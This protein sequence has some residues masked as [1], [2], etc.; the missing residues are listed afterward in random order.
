MSSVRYSETQS[1]NSEVSINTAFISPTI[2][3][4]SVGYGKVLSVRHVAGSGGD[5]AKIVC[6]PNGVDLSP[7]TPDV[8]YDGGEGRQLVVM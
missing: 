6:I 5:P 2:L 7:Y 4:H 3:S 8:A 1:V